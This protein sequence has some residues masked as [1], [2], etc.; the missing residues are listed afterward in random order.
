MREG[1]VDAG[2]GSSPGLH[3]IVRLLDDGS[4]PQGAL[5]MPVVVACGGG[6]GPGPT[7][8]PPPGPRPEANADAR[9]TGVNQGTHSL[10][11]NRTQIAGET[12][13]EKN[14]RVGSFL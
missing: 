10:E 1:R 8:R 3:T 13:K 9:H 2:K 6:M 11:G 14:K 7:I 5:E 12:M 4:V